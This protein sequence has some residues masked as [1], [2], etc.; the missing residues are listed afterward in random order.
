MTMTRAFR[1]FV[2]RLMLGVLVFGQMA[3]AA[4]ACPA[5]SGTPQILPAMAMN[6]SVEKIPDYEAVSLMAASPDMFAM[7]VTS[8]MADITGCNHIDESA[9]NQCVEHCHFGQ[10][11]VGH[12]SAA[13]VP[14]AL[15]ATLYTL[16]FQHEPFGHGWPSADSKFKRIVA[17]RPHAILHCC[18][19]I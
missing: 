11:S 12:A 19:R 7:S 14:A 18:F 16:P 2:C 3:I 1:R 8:D 4:Y 9:A 17:S 6:E 10:Q 15:L 13:T 5:L